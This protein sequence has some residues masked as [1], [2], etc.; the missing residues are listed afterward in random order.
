LCGRESLRS[1][2][3][4]LASD[5]RDAGDTRDADDTKDTKDTKEK[6]CRA[7]TCA[8]TCAASAFGDTKGKSGVAST[9]ADT[10]EKSHVLHEIESKASV[11]FTVRLK[12]DTTVVAAG[13]P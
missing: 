7:S 3:L 6:S 13:Q 12:A 8:G 5:A 1:D 11:V 10:K 2:R 9:F 4:L